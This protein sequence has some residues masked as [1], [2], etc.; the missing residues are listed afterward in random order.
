M[1]T[2]SEKKIFLMSMLLFFVIN[3]FA[4]D[5]VTRQD[6]N[7]KNQPESFKLELIKNKS[8]NEVLVEGVKI[9]K[10]VAK[11][12]PEG[13]LDHVS[14]EKAIKLNHI[15]VDSYE[16]LNASAQNN[17]CELMLKNE[18]DLGEYNYL[19]KENER[20]NIEVNLK[21]CFFQLALY[22][23]VEIDNIK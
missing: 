17:G 2:L 14:K 12:Y 5:D 9:D 3:A 22:S 4:Q 16:L 11:Y 21:G 6:E 15:Y 13:E 19:R 18:F 10:R 8:A 1:N 20:V 23:W 7:K